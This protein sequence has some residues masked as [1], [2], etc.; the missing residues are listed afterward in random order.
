MLGYS[1]LADVST[2]MCSNKMASMIKLI[3]T[4]HQRVSTYN[5][6]PVIKRMLAFSPK[7]SLAELLVQP[8]TSKYTQA[9][10]TL[11]YFSPLVN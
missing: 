4:L 5:Y 9:G 11:F 2:L 1:K 6:E 10:V 8:I 3:P 7:Y